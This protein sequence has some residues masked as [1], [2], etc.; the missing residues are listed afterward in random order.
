MILTNTFD[1]DNA[2]VYADD[3]GL[4]VCDDAIIVVSSYYFI[5]VYLY[6]GVLYVSRM[7]LI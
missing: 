2:D 6:R 5:L 3:A 1:N 4:V 7:Q